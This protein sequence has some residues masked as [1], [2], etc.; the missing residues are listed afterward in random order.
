V[1]FT[2]YS[3][4]TCAECY[5]LNEQLVELGVSAA[6]RWRGVQID[7]AVPS[8]MRALDRRS[9]DRIEDEIAEVRRRVDGVLIH[10]PRGK[11]NTLKAIVAVASVMRQQPARA[12]IFRD[13]LYRAYWRDGTDLSS[14]AELQRV[15]DSA[16]VPRFVELDHPDAEETVEDWDL[17]WATE[18]LGG[19]PRVIR[20]DGKILWGLKPTR[21]AS[22]FFGM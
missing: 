8:P 5:G 22:A 4:F 1:E 20:A 19:V 14:P 16:A 17:D 15:A 11:P 12:A 13:A 2:V 3:D 10:L 6:V 7:P 21:E 18:R 9:L